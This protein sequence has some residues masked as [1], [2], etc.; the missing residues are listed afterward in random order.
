MKIK[1]MISIFM[2]TVLLTVN[3]SNVFAAEEQSDL[4]LESIYEEYKDDEQ[5]QLMRNEYGEEY[6]E[7]FLTDVLNSRIESSIVP[8]G[9]GGNE[10]YQ[11]VKNIKQTENYN[12]GTTSV[13]QTLYALNSQGNVSGS[14]DADKIATLDKQYN[15]N[16]KDGT[17]VAYAV[18]ALNTYNSG[19]ARYV[20]VLGSS[21]PN[22]AT[23]ESYVAT[24][25]T[26][27]KPVL[28]HAITGHIG[29]YGGRSFRHYLSLDYINRTTDMVRIVDCNKNDAYYG[30]HYVELS[31]AYSSIH[32]D[33]G[34]YLIY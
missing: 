2:V 12:C 6:A 7:T 13:L 8:Y 24:S 21:I 1:R 5:Y 9:G 10:C 15:V 22:E 23:F 17:I 20:C 18:N 28:L 32:S 26:N 31:E 19:N 3:S 25:L 27:C 4:N 14:S 30:I 34:R 11:Y 16:S 33:S 29:Y